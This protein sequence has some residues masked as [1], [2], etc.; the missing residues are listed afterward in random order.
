MKHFSDLQK[1]E[2]AVLSLLMCAEEERHRPLKTAW[3]ASRCQM[4][5]MDAYL[6]N[7]VVPMFLSKFGFH[8]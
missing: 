7:L 6:Q 8:T 4:R 1:S 2:T 5:R 3:R